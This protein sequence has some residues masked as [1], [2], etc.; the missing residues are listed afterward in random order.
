MFCFYVYNENFNYYMDI[1]QHRSRKEMRR[2]KKP[3]AGAETK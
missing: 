2:L 3:S 1:G